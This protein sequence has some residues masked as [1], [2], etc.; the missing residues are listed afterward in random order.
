[1]KKGKRKRFASEMHRSLFLDS[2]A[3]PGVQDLYSFRINHYGIQVQFQN[4]GVGG[5]Q[6]SYLSEEINQGFD[7]QRRTATVA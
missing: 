4:F 2:K 3:Q 1:M 5:C 7:V 6:V